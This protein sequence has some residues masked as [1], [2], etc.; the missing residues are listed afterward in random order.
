MAF[1]TRARK[2]GATGAALALVTVL[3][4]AAASYATPAVDRQDDAR[5]FTCGAAGQD[6]SGPG[7]FRFNT[8]AC[9]NGN[10]TIARLPLHRGTSH[11]ETVWYVIMD[12]SSQTDAGQLHVNFA[13]K[14][15]NVTK[16]KATPA[17]FQTVSISNGVVD[18]PATVDF[19]HQRVLVPGP[20][21]FP[22]A[23]TAPPAVG[24]AGYSPLILMPDGTVRNAPQI[25]N[26]TG[27]ADKV[28]S[29]DRDSENGTVLY[30]ETEGRYEDKHVHYASFDSSSPVAA[31]IEDV[32]YAP[33]LGNAPTQGD[34]GLT[35][36]ARE[37]LDAFTN[38]PIGE[39]NPQRQG[40]NSAILDK[41]DPHNILHEVPALPL[42]ADVGSTGYAPEWDI[43][44]AE[45]TQTAIAAG[46]RAELRSTDEVDQR[47]AAGLVT[48]FGGTTFGA[49]GF[50]VN[51]PLISID[52]P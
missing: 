13:P 48:G 21:G 28:V 35:S 50:I 22:P 17:P 10:S 25:A 14:L 40:L 43:H 6:H 37:R 11:G 16:T 30:R 20:T 24:E 19:D 4:F 52:I 1:S 51:C 8:S 44:L 2:L 9:E 7:H 23:S 31:A 47:V 18:F 36:S 27:H 38:G 39:A 5:D 49:S 45:W 15:A 32:T 42:H 12:S 33:A 29:I 41:M 34:E 3:P 26:K 46:D